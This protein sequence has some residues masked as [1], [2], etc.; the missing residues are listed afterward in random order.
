MGK[1]STLLPGGLARGGYHRATSRVLLC[2]APW[3]WRGSPL[4]L[5]ADGGHGVAAGDFAV[6]EP[7]PVG[8][9]CGGNGG[10]GVGPPVWPPFGGS[11][12]CPHPMAHLGAGAIAQWPVGPPGAPRRRPLRTRPPPGPTGS[13][14]G[15][16]KA[17]EREGKATA[18]APQVAPPAPP[19]LIPELGGHPVS[20]S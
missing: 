20:T 16:R 7:L 5:V 11:G 17:T 13:Q 3:G 2:S 12:L 4:W 1:L 14:L 8:T 6:T 15:E 10:Q 9:A 18:S 19:P